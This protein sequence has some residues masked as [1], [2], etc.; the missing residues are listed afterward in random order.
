MADPVVQRF[1]EFLDAS[2]SPFHAAKQA[3]RLLEGAG[4][5]AIDEG[6]EPGELAPGTRAYVLRG[7][8]IVAFRVGA[9]PP[10]SAGFRMVAAHTDSPNLRVKPRPLMTSQGYV[11]LG[12]E[13][14]GGV[15]LAS[16]TDR[17][18]GIAGRVVL[19][20][21]ED[22]TDDLVDLRQ[23]LCRIPNIAVHLN[24]KVND[25]GL[26][27]N[28]Q[29]DLPAVFALER[30]DVAD[31][32][33]TL[34]AEEV[35]CEPSDLLAWDLGLY[36]LTPAALAGA[37]QEFVNS[38]RLDNLTSC[39]AGLEALLGA[40]DD[41]PDATAV[42]GLFDHEEIGSRTGRGAQSAL[43]EAVLRQ[44]LVHATSTLRATSTA[45][46]PTRG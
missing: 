7:G 38:A 10:A 30:E 11:R 12:L 44:V 35:G 46:W 13:P 37:H 15:I 31:P 17:D 4:Y 21:G 41:L 33:R 27:L 5:T 9:A 43:L 26:K 16:W 39:H 34:L 36:D 6:A 1:L 14:Y 45:R 19:R 2:P 28:A 40:G 32:F 25:E 20:D 23:P 18:L 29:T 42:L 3:A 22:V 24:R 8:S